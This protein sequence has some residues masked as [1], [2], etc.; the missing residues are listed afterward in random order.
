MLSNLFKIILIF[1]IFICKSYSYKGYTIDTEGKNVVTTSIRDQSGFNSI[2][3]TEIG[4][5][6][7]YKSDSSILS[8]YKFTNND[9]NQRYN[10]SFICQYSSNKVVL[11]RDTTIF[12]ITFGSNGVDTLEKIGGNINPNITNL[13]CNYASKKY[14][15]TYLSSNSK[16]YYFKASD[17]NLVTSSSQAHSIISSSCF[18]S[19]ASLVLCINIISESNTNKLAY[20]Y[21]NSDSSSSLASN[22]ITLTEYKINDAII[23]YYSNSE[24]VL[25]LSAKP[26]KITDDI[27]LYCY[28]LNA[29]INS[30]TLTIKSP[31]FQAIDKINGTITYCDVA[32]LTD[33]YL[34][35]SICLSYYYRTTYI[36]SIFQYNSGTNQFNFYTKN[37]DTFKDLSFPLLMVSPIS[38]MAFRQNTL[39][40][41]YQDIDKDS[42]ILV[43]YPNCGKNFDYVPLE[44]A[45]CHL[46]SNS[47]PSYYF[48]ECTHSFLRKTTPNIPVGYTTYDKNQFCK[49]KK[50]ECDSNF[51]L[52]NFVDGYYKCR[53]KNEEIN[54]YYFDNI[55]NKFKKCYRSCLKC[56][57]DG[58]DNDNNCKECDEVNGFYPFPHISSR[59]C[60]HKEEP[61]NKYYFNETN[62]QF[63]KCRDECSLCKEGSDIPDSEPTDETKDTKCTKCDI[64]NGYYPQ[65]D[66]PSNCIK[67]D[68]NN[69]ATDTKNIK[70]YYPNSD[71]KRW[72]KCTEGC[73]YCNEYGSSIYDTKCNNLKLNDNFCDESKGYFHVKGSNNIQN[74]FNK[75]VRYDH[76]YFDSNEKIFKDCNEACLQCDTWGNTTLY[77]SNTTCLENKCDEENN[78]FPS[79]DDPTT[80]YKYNVNPPYIPHYYLDPNT[81]IFKRCHEA[82]FT[83]LE[84]IEVNENDT[85]CYSC[86]SNNLYYPLDGHDNPNNPITCYNLNRPGYYYKNG[87]MY[88]CPDKCTLCEYT[89]LT[90]SLS[91]DV[92]CTQ[93]NNA[94]GFYKIEGEFLDHPIFNEKY[95]ECYTWRIEKIK[96]DS[97]KNKPP[98][99]NTL[100]DLN[101]NVFKICNAACTK[102]TAIDYS[103]YSPHCQAKQCSSGYIYVQNH[104]D[105]CFPENGDFDLH[106]VY[107]DLVLNEKYFKPCYQTCKTCSAGGTRSINNCKVCRDGYIMHPNNITNAYNCIFNCLTLDNNNYYYLDEDNNDE[108]ICVEKCPDKYP[109]LLPE[110]KRCLKTCETEPVL[111]YSKDRICVSPCPDGTID[112]IKKECV[113]I[114]NECVKS[115]LESNLILADVND[116]NINKLIIDYCQDYS[117]TSNQIN[118]ITNKLNEFNI[119]LYKNRRCVEEFYGDDINF[120]DLSVCFNDLKNYYELSLNQDL[121]VMI[122]NCDDNEYI[123]K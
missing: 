89:R 107:E 120:P 36:L 105:I 115:D 99:L 25:C 60:I 88:K 70:Y 116:T 20:Y 110:K 57:G 12:E 38:I 46:F 42:M 71:Y 1:T 32:N 13:H 119:I 114:S 9:L 31:Q 35:A 54:R 118:K 90:D 68:R 81:K 47:Q 17:K 72:D 101:N 44:G 27:F 30:K 87:K 69:D 48:D 74:C 53:N 2:A 121:I 37:S 56:F 7:K 6:I 41:F 109:F 96:E 85:Q 55:D 34:Y 94:L 93:C 40:I 22:S 83:C 92:Y 73:K 51:V 33:N 80:C 18:L 123:K 15:Y 65:I 82:C 24:I 3:F 52:D 103:L 23:K 10:K 5:L 11:T 86:N 8:T 16:V 78:Y 62:K 49:I 84:Q 100:L 14:I 97:D 21:H 122:M 29:D 45:G 58:N 98:P 111:K 102:C 61:I 63:T 59:Q 50:I 39:G 4:T 64:D 43:F 112:N 117:Y 91:D 113:S 108:Y 106:F 66:K 75:D 79:E 77:I 104:E 28:M 19:D 76:Y 95:M 26:T 67:S